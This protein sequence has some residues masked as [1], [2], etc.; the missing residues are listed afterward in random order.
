MR[1][2]R[3]RLIFTAGWIAALCTGLAFGVF[4]A[5]RTYHVQETVTF[6]NDGPGECTQL[7]IVIGLFRDWAPYIDVLSES[8]SPSSYRVTSDDFGNR[9]AELVLRDV[10]RGT[11]IPITID[12]QI[13]VADLAFDLE[14]HDDSEIPE[15]I[16]RWLDSEPFIEST[17][18]SIVLQANDL[19]CGREGPGEI[20]EAIYDHVTSSIRY[21]GHVAEP[22]G[23]LYC[24]RNQQGDCTEFAAL[25]TALCRA[26]GIPARMIEGVT[27][28]AEDE[29]HSWMEA[30]LPGLGWIPFD[31]TWGRHPGEREKYLAAITPDHIPLVIGI[32][33][34]AL[35]GY[36]YWAYWYWWESQSTSISITGYDWDVR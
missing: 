12:W 36:S 23:A 11:R 25:M 8:I 15:E 16:A 10:P 31:P 24:L 32:D 5:S 7:K 14:D 33:L 22:Q 29:V 2:G 20:V 27:N 30:Y 34:D 3:S 17:D 26:A 28:R 18:P 4:G 6:I 1:A 19:A 21:E 9:F 13:E 35:G